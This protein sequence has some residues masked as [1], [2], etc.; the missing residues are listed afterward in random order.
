MLS[1]CCFRGHCLLWL[2]FLS[3]MFISTPAA[4]AQLLPARSPDPWSDYQIIMWQQQTKAAYS[5]LEK[6]GVSAAAVHSES[7]TGP[8]LDIGL[9][10]Y[11]ENIA[12]DF[13]SPYHRWSGD[14]PVN[15]KFEIARDDYLRDP[16]GRTALERKPSLSDP[17]WLARISARLTRTVEAHPQHRPLFYNLGDE[18]GIADL[19]ILWDFDFSE[20]S[21]RGMRQWLARRYRT[22]RTQP[23]VG[24]A[25]SRLE[26]RHADDDARGDRRHG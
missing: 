19:S 4:A 26:L 10:W 20:P 25:V 24:H 15:W 1:A 6:I 3:L 8:L 16:F 9:G 22:G 2:V 12:T 17:A 11:V 21:L 18:T 5:A 7:A 13:Y 14:R 23:R